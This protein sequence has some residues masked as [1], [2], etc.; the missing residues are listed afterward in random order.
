EWE[1][2]VGWREGGGRCEGR[3]GGIL[4]GAQFLQRPAEFARAGLYI[5]EQT[6]ILDRD[7]CLVGESRYQLDL[8]IGERTHFETRQRQNADRRPLAQHRNTEDGAKAAQL[9]RLIK[10][11]IGIRLHI[12]NMNDLALKQGSSCR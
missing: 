9:S 1:E 3:K 10:S 8:L 4:R 12:G 6:N 5:F 11:V 2:G 7:C